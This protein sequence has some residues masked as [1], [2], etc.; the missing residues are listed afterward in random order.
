MSAL[1]QKILPDASRT[2]ALKGRPL[3]FFAAMALAAGPALLGCDT[4]PAIPREVALTGKIPSQRCIVYGRVLVEGWPKTLLE[5]SN[6]SVEFQNLTT[7]EKSSYLLDKDG[8][9]SLPV[10]PGRY[11]VTGIWSGL[12]SVEPGKNATPILFAAPPGVLVYLGTLLILLPS[13]DARGQIVIRDEFPAATRTL[14]ERYPA[15]FQGSPPLKGLLVAVPEK[16][17]A[18]ILVDVV[19]SRRL[20][21]LML[22]DSDSPYTILTRETARAFGVRPDKQPV[23]MNLQTY[24]G[25]ILSLPMRLKSIRLGDFELQNVEVVVDVDGYFPIGILGKSILGHFKVTVD[26]KRKEAKFER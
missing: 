5:S 4:L 2:R 10:L 15:L 19:L 14:E 26:P 25:A 11:A 12:Q 18:G 16:N 21:A 8:A 17:M 9:F 1:C 22:L 6:V 20:A 24:G 13:R 7:R 23:G 3:A